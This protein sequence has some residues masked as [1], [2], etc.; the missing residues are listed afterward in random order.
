MGCDQNTH[1]D[2]YGTVQSASAG[3]EPGHQFFLV[4]GGIDGHVGP[5]FFA[6]RLGVPQLLFFRFRVIAGIQLSEAGF[7][8]TVYGAGDEGYFNSGI[9]QFGSFVPEFLRL[10]INSS[11]CRISGGRM[12]APN[13]TT[14]ASAAPMTVMT[15]QGRENL[16]RTS[17][18]TMGS[19][20]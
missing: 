15:A 17:Q 5:Q 6:G 3:R 4:E 13:P 2:S 14:T 10:S 11:V 16:R 9:N 1:H 8:N 18:E 20:R 7:V 12:V 19:S